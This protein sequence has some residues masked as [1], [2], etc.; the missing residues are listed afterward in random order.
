MEWVALGLIGVG[1]IGALLAAAT[2]ST[3][4]IWESNEV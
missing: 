2:A 4:R 1:G 3:L